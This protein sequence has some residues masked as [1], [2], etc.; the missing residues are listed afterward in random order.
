MTQVV[1]SGIWTKLL[2]HDVDVYHNSGFNINVWIEGGQ[3]KSA[4]PQQATVLL[5]H[6]G[7]TYPPG[8]R[9]PFAGL[10]AF[11]YREAINPGPWLHIPPAPKHVIVFDSLPADGTHP[12]FGPLI[13]MDSGC[14]ALT[15]QEFGPAITAEWTDRD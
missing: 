4:A 9:A 13:A 7:G 14:Q 6:H 11:G 5:R 2:D 15:E 8:W 1:M 12:A 3:F 10:W